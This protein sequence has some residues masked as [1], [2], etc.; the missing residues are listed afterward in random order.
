M[1]EYFLNQFCTRMKSKLLGIKTTVLVL[2][3]ALFIT[4]G[5]SCLVKCS[6][7][8]S[9]SSCGPVHS[10]RSKLCERPSG[11][12]MG[13]HR[14]SVRSF[15]ATFLRSLLKRARISE[16]SKEEM[17][18]VWR[19]YAALCQCQTWD[20]RERNQKDVQSIEIPRLDT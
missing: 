14:F 11:T 1:D 2:C 4:L 15:P 5:M 9:L 20:S 8:L 17:R 3:T 18:I 10:K 7:R 6:K 19:R 16:V 12:G 13:V